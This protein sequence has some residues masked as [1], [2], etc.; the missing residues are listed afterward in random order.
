MVIVIV[1][2]VGRVDVVR[3]VVAVVGNVA[4]A[5]TVVVVLPSRRPLSS[6]VVTVVRTAGRRISAV[7]QLSGP[8]QKGH[9][10]CPANLSAARTD[11]PLNALSKRVNNA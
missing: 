5:G 1:E 8:T 6:V 7:R 10:C 11:P 4:V 9:T 2:V 3:P